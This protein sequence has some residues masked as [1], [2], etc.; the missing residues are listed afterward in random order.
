MK[1]NVF[2]QAIVVLV[3]MSMLV[4]ACAPAATPAPAAEPAKPAEPAQPAE[5][6]KPTEPAAVVEPTK[7]PEPT[8][9]A[10]VAPAAAP[11][12]E[13]PDVQ[14]GQFNVAFVLIGPHDDGGYSQAHFD[15]LTYMEKNVPNVHAAYIENVAEGADSEQVFRSLARKGF[16]LI[17]GTSFGYMDPMEAVAAD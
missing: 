12:Y 15:G 13:I 9:P 14:E 6:A 10:A 3:L 16:N 4:S 2:W 11:S 7:A 8:Q 17:F 5:P 1:K